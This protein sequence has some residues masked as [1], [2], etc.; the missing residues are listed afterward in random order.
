VVKLNSDLFLQSKENT[1]SKSVNISNGFA[2]NTGSANFCKLT[3]TYDT[4]NNLEKNA[5]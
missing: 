1:E 3:W 5:N 4:Y 2:Y